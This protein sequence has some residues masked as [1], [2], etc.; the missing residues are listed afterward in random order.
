MQQWVRVA[1]PTDDVIVLV[2][3][4]VSGH[5][6][7]ILNRN[8]HDVVN[9]SHRHN[10]HGNILSYPYFGVV[11]CYEPLQHSTRIVIS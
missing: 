6:N 9:L 5:H 7:H 2:R 10:C 3:G 11:I 8:I 1:T 4:I